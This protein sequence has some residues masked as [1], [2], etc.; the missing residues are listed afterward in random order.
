MD[1]VHR[2]HAE[3]LALVEQPKETW[4]GSRPRARGTVLRG[5]LEVLQAFERRCR[6]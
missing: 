2:R 4:I 1:E 5:L 6:R 3:K